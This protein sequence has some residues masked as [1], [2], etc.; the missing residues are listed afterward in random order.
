VVTCSYGPDWMT[1]HSSISQ[2]FEER[3]RCPVAC[4]QGEDCAA[5][6]Q[7]FRELLGVRFGSDEVSCVKAVRQ[8]ESGE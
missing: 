3:D 1:S 8:F 5:T 4:G 6:R 7:L 2:I